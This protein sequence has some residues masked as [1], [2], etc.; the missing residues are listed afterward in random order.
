MSEKSHTPGPWKYDAG[1]GAIYYDDGDVYPLVAST[2]LESVSVEQADADGLLIAAA[3]D[4]LSSLERFVVWHGK[5]DRETDALL[6]IEQ[7][8]IEIGAAMRAIAKATS[9]ALSQEQQP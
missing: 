5:R 7:Q 2:N 3:P 6:P 4:L 9:S 8:D 1:S